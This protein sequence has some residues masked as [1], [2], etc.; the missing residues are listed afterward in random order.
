MEKEQVNRRGIGGKFVNIAFSTTLEIEQG[1]RKTVRIKTRIHYQEKGQGSCLLLLHDAG[2]SGAVY[3]KLLAALSETYRVIVPD[4]PGHGASGCPDMNY[5]VQDFSLAIEALLKALGISKCTIVACGQSAAYGIEYCFYNQ[6]QV[7]H[8]VLINPG[9]LRDLDFAQSR[10]LA[11]FWG[12]WLIRRWQN[13]AYMRKQLEKAFFDKTALQEQDVRAF[14]RPYS[15]EE[16]QFCVRLAVANYD[17]GKVAEQIKAL[18]IPILYLQGGEDIFSEQRNTEAF[19][20][21]TE[22]PYEMQI[23]NCGACLQLEKGQN[24]AMG[25]L[26]FLQDIEGK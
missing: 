18:H 21:S 1:R 19:I 13:P 16:V 4:L 24:T 5:T 10:R 3:R 25:I 20:Q 22:Q 15:R 8:M 6:K 14:C 2:H 11:G 23:R 9:A 17:E 12:K 26:R 7:S